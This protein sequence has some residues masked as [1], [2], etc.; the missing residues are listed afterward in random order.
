MNSDI[1]NPDQEPVYAGF[2]RRG[3]AFL[4][5]IFLVKVG[6]LILILAGLGAAWQAMN[7]LDLSSP[8]EDLVFLLAG[9]FLLTVITLFGIYFLYFNYKGASPGKRLLGLKITT[10]SGEPIRLSQ[11]ITR[12]FGVLLSFFF[13]FIGFFFIFFNKKKMALHDMLAGTYVVE[14]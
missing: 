2:F 3:L 8:S 5:D 6:S 14:T 7:D 10:Q 12:T 13:F 9:I 11:A 4:I 1:L